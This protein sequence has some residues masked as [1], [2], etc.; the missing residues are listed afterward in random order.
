MDSI[1]EFF[2]QQYQRYL[3]H[4]YKNKINIWLVFASLGIYCMYKLCVYVCVRIKRT[5]WNGE[6]KKK[7]M[8]RRKQKC[9]ILRSHS[10]SRTIAI[11][12][13]R[14]VAGTVLVIRYYVEIFFLPQSNDVC[15]QYIAFVCYVCM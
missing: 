11:Y 2:K 12:L 6:K 13:Q 15:R 14:C 4:I 8:F 1:D 5:V 9:F 10:F 3:Y 7:I